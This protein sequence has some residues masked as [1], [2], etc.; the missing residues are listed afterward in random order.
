EPFRKKGA[1]IY[2][3]AGNHDWDKSGVDG[4][5]KIKAQEA[6][7]KGI[8]DDKIRFVPTAGTLGPF[9]EML[10]DSI[11]TILY[12]SEFWLFPHHEAG[13]LPEIEKE[14]QRFLFSLDSIAKVHKDK[15]LL[16]LCHHPMKSYGEHSLKFS[17]S[18]HLFPLRRFWK[19]LYIPLPVVGSVYPLLRSTAFR[20]AE[21]LKHPTYREL[22]Q[23]VT[24]VLQDHPQVIYISGH[25]HGLQFIQDERFTQVISGS[26][27][28][29][30]HISKAK[31]L[32][33]KHG[34]Q[35][36]AVMDFLQNG[37]IRV[38]FYIVD[39]DLVTKDFETVLY[40]D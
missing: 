12:D 18:E 36:F 39:Q 15:K 8:G 3:I 31:D 21:D 33:Y 34:Q 11:V 40:K 29:T 24:K 37:Q 9:V 2:F 20:T 38:S 19:G 30:S 35:G 14:K 1:T 32:H 26:G 27:A 16:V 22:I 28:K 25:D 4:L 5:A 7:L 13:L 6:F 17:V 23:S 10:T